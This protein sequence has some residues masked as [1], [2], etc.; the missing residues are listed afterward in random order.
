[1]N[2]ISKIEKHECTGCGACH[3]S[4]PKGAISMQYDPEGFLFPA[5]DKEK[6]INCGICIKRCPLNALQYTNNDNPPC[7]AV[8]AND[9]IRKQSASGG[10]FGVLANFILEQQGMVC[11]AA[12]DKEYKVEHILISSTDD[13]YKIQGT[14]Y[15]QSNTSKIYTEIRKN[16]ENNNKPILFVGT[17]CQVAGLKAYLNKEYENLYTVDLICHG[18]PSPGIWQKYLKENFNKDKIQNIIF[19]NKKYG[20]NQSLEIKTGDITY[21]GRPP[22]DIFYETFFILMNTR[23]SCGDCKFAKL[24]RQG[25]LT[26]ADAWE[27]DK[28]MNDNKGTSEVLINSDKGSYLFEQVK[29]NFQKYKDFSI[30][31]AK[32]GNRAITQSFSSHP[33]RDYFFA[34]NNVFTV[35][36]SYRRAI[37]QSYDIG[38]MGIWFFPNYG[39]VLTTFALIKVLQTLGK[40]ILLIDNSGF[41][42]YEKFFKY[43]TPFNQ[44]DFLSQYTDISNKLYTI[45]ELKKMNNKINTFVVGSDQ[46]FTASL[47][48]DC[49]GYTYFLDFVDTCKRKI[50]YATSFGPNPYFS[51]K[52]FNIIKPLLQK[53]NAISVREN[54]YI[55]LIKKNFNIDVDFA[56]DPVFLCNKAEYEKLADSIINIENREPVTAYI[57]DISQ[58]ISDLLNETKKNIGTGINIIPD[59]PAIA[60]E[61]TQKYFTERIATNVNISVWLHYFKNSDYIITDSFHGLCFSIIFKKK[62]IA[63][64]NQKRGATRFYSL[65]KILGLTDRL[66]E[67]E[68]IKQNIPLIIETLKTEVDYTSV[69]KILDKEKE[70]SYAWLKKAIN[71]NP[72]ISKYKK[73]KLLIRNLLNKQQ[74]RGN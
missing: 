43:P 30:E 71:T 70:K 46:L 39:C 16:L 5:I 57:L 69:Y 4:C 58:E 59:A 33:Q 34:L 26:I 31:Q 29:N 68:K 20:W 3:N 52:N 56:L 22:Q 28:D 47:I 25:D 65:M 62:F 7:Y 32:K 36:E 37:K 42:N 19:R 44:K 64:L 21:K 48:N 50:S 41:F 53:F 35:K 18:V 8:I 14:K 2:N 17:P 11:G 51:D 6:C 63:L 27:C 24:P 9:E 10:A 55:K 74:K 12:W 40:N 1:M 72:K 38:L 73:T 13:L 23:K 67:K 54:T 60:A 45:Q 49:N 61:N 66:F 15:L